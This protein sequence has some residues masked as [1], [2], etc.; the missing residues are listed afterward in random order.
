MYHYRGPSTTHV[1]IEARVRKSSSWRQ[2]APRAANRKSKKQ[3]NHGARERPIFR[4]PSL[5]R[6]WSYGR[7]TFRRAW[8][9]HPGCAPWTAKFKGDGVC[10]ANEGSPSTSTPWALAASPS[11]PRPGRA[12]GRSSN[13]AGPLLRRPTVLG[14][15]GVA[16]RAVPRV[17]TAL[18]TMGPELRIFA[19]WGPMH[20][21][22]S[23][24]NTQY[25]SHGAHNNQTAV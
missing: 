3:S 13:T 17:P 10:D 15:R 16:Q 19:W 21:M 23:G 12:C 5:R 6:K 7:G 18:E 1:E 2:R 9:T 11:S 25:S 8:P 22:Q 4:H 20:I 24:I 14:A